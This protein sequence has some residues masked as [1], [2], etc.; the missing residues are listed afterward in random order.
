MA[1]RK[2]TLVVKLKLGGQPQHV[3]HLAQPLSK[4]KRARSTRKPS[5]IVTLKN[6]KSVA[7]ATVNNEEP[8]SK[9]SKVAFTKRR[10][11]AAHTG[12]IRRK[13]R[14][15]AKPSKIVVLKYGKTKGTPLQKRLRGHFANIDGEQ[16][17]LKEE[18]NDEDYVPEVKIATKESA[19]HQVTTRSRRRALVNVG[20][21]KEVTKITKRTKVKRTITV[22]SDLPKFRKPKPHP[23]FKAPRN[24][25][26][27]DW[28]PW[29]DHPEPSLDHIMAVYELLRAEIK[30]KMNKDFGRTSNSVQKTLDNP[31]DGPL[32]AS[33]E[34]SV[35]SLVNMIMSQA[36]SNENAIMA[37]HRMCE[38]YPYWVKGQRVVTEIP[39]Y[40]DIRTGSTEKLQGAMKHGGL[41]FGRSKRVKQI[42]DIVFTENQ[43]RS[44]ET[45]ASVNQPEAQDFVPG[46]LSLDFLRKKSAREIYSYLIELPGINAKT[47]HCVLAFSL[48]YP[49]FVVDVH[50]MWMPWYLGWLP[51]DVDMA[52]DRIMAA[53]HLNFHLPDELK[54]PLHQ[55][56]WHHRQLCTTCGERQKKAKTESIKKS[57]KK[58]T[59]VSAKEPKS[60]V[61]VLEDLVVRRWTTEY[62]EKR[63]ARK[64]RSAK[65]KANTQD[66]EKDFDSD[67]KG[68]LSPSET[69]SR[70][71]Q[72]KAQPKSERY[73]LEEHELTVE[74]A[75]KQGYRLDHF[76]IDDDFAVSGAKHTRPRWVKVLREDFK[77]VSFDTPVS[78]PSGISLDD[79]LVGSEKKNSVLDKLDND[80]SPDPDEA[81][82]VSL[83][84]SDQDDITSDADEEDDASMD[85]SDDEANGK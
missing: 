73:M 35:H 34:L 21:F 46:A 75:S 38:E 16:V 45:L 36:T 42:L 13:A 9:S 43:A 50:C 3:L 8:P 76:A 1:Q 72:K 84:I 57:T 53:S 41:Q 85:I 66:V 79:T 23:E 62:A 68:I 20:T 32:H 61:C 29:I 22:V 14:S 47:A 17:F 40:H 59:K 39:N 63:K 11:S 33:S 77:L 56:F 51:E 70:K 78:T 52:S 27:W 31:I 83:D 49:V 44:Q 28:T 18:G 37:K 19:T 24:I 74:Q 30:E 82:D 58:S 71:R 12:N 26:Y 69:I 10:T 67:E 81:D 65:R 5:K 64:L 6:R 80:T 2:P 54:Y 55:L 4:P 60:S 7:Q 48:G 15:V 25:F